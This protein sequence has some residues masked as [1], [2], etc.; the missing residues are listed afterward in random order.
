MMSEHLPECHWNSPCSSQDGTHDRFDTTDFCSEC[1]SLCICDA[2]M[3]CEERG[4]TAA[5]QRVEA[6]YSRAFHRWDDGEVSYIIPPSM[7]ILAAIKAGK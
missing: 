3:R 1:R 2:L 5:V 6:L 4:L 7:E